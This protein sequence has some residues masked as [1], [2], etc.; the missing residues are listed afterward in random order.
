MDR[1]TKELS[2]LH[3]GG[4]EDSTGSVHK[5]ELVTGNLSQRLQSN[6]LNRDPAPH[7]LQNANAP[8]ASEINRQYAKSSIFD[9]QKTVR[10]LNTKI[11]V[12]IRHI[13]STNRQPSLQLQRTQATP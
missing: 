2:P 13:E 12:I 8:S 5:Q 11:Q 4:R 7:A 9:A 1:T 6:T 3:G 10:N